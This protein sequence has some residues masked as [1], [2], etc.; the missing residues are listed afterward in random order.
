MKILLTGSGGFLGKILTKKLQEK[1]D[2]IEFDLSQGFD[3]RNQVQ[4]EMA[5][6]ESDLVVHT[7]AVADL[8]IADKNVDQT[9]DI[10]VLGTI[11]VAKACSKHNKKHIY[12]S[13][14]CAYGNQ[15]NFPITEETQPKPTEIY[16]WSKFA[17]EQIVQGQFSRFQ[18]E[19][20]ILRL[21]TFYGI[22]MR[23]SLVPYVFMEQAFANKPITIHG[24]GE[25]T[26]TLTYV[27]DIA[28]GINSAVNSQIK[29]EIINITTEEE[30]S[31]NQIAQTVKKLTNSP[32]EIINT[33]DRAGQIYKEVISAQ[34][35]KNLLGWQAQVN[36]EAG[37]QRVYNWFINK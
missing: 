19:F 5:V 1:H 10:N 34:K 35:A 25:Q 18:T 16:A 12:I 7:A 30:V 4:V 22:E 26:R 2:V 14:V 31:V 13:T 17:G 24:N 20:L 8:Y 9:W 23:S 36:F 37:M 29:N 11:N 33:P 21:A 32:S 6:K 27:D 28:D 3:I 15:T